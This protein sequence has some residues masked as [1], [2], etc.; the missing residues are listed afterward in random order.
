M[1]RLALLFTMLTFA[2]A[3]ALLLVTVRGCGAMPV[4]E[5]RYEGHVGEFHTFK[6]TAEEQHRDFIIEQRI[7]HE[8][9][10][11]VLRVLGERPRAHPRR[12]T[13]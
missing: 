13:E 6:S 1:R 8:D 12:D 3:L 7:Q 9:I 2:L 11:E 4:A 10:H 5:I